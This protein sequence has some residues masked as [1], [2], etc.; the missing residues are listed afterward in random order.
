MD[1]KRLLNVLLDNAGAMSPLPTTVLSI[2]AIL[3]QVSFYLVKVIKD[4]DA[5]TAI[6]RLARLEDP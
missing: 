6:S 1:Q 3:H 2:T 4:T 5:I